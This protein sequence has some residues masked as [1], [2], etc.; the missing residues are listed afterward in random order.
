MPRYLQAVS[1]RKTTAIIAG[2]AGAVA[3]LAA[4]LLSE[5]VYETHFTIRI[6]RVWY[7]ENR[8]IGMES[9]TELA[10]ILTSPAFA[11]ELK[12]SL[13]L[14]APLRAIQK[15]IR[16]MFSERADPNNVGV[17]TVAV[18]GPTRVETLRLAQAVAAKTTERHNKGFDAAIVVRKKW[19]EDFAS[20]VTASERE[21]GRLREMA[22]ALLKSGRPD[23]QALV[24]QAD[25][26]SREANLAKLREKYREVQTENT[27]LLSQ[28]S[29]VV[30]G[31]YEPEKPIKPDLRR[32]AILG[33]VGGLLV[34]LFYAFIAEAVRI[35]AGT[36]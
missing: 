17:L 32:N 12:D 8:A 18:R 29:Q 14:K 1:R 27:E 10:E 28:K 5:K 31:P 19:E 7:E 20:Q 36:R 16:P 25:L 34:Y 13:S 4:G 3:A 30:S 21:I 23:S 26:E 24:L 2:L 9:A 35:G 15:R 22:L 6:G 11:R 33:L